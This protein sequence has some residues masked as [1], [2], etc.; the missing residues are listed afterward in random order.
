MYHMPPTKSFKKLLVQIDSAFENLMA[1]LEP[2]EPSPA[3][4][5]TQDSAWILASSE[6][7][8]SG[9]H[10]GMSRSRSVSA[11]R[12]F[13]NDCNQASTHLESNN[14]MA[15]PIQ[16]INRSP[17]SFSDAIYS[18][19]SSD[20]SSADTLYTLDTVECFRNTH[21]RNQTYNRN[22]C[23]NSNKANAY[24]DMAVHNAFNSGN[25]DKNGV[26]EQTTAN[27]DDYNDQDMASTHPNARVFLADSDHLNHHT[28][29]V[30]QTSTSTNSDG[31]LLNANME[32]GRH[33]FSSPPSTVVSQP[34]LNAT[35]PLSD[36]T[37]RVEH[38]PAVFSTLSK[39]TFSKPLTRH[40][41]STNQI[42]DP[43]SDVPQHTPDITHHPQLTYTSNKV[44]SFYQTISSPH[45]FHLDSASIEKSISTSSQISSTLDYPHTKHTTSNFTTAGQ[46]IIPCRVDSRYMS[47]DDADP[48]PSKLPLA[49]VDHV[50]PQPEITASYWPFH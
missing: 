20:I 48:M 30:H 7:D 31:R 6:C 3:A 38:V 15:D 43:P 28:E 39:P 50:L 44:L 11:D 23:R 10:T 13:L 2:L 14:S 36:A 40:H 27:C 18:N 16:I 12:T 5:C 17:S 49:S 21:I 22:D 32:Y 29:N 47:G 41:Q 9:I 34:V 45:A 25:V 19:T 35:K 4:L 46:L 26:V 8:R 37:S 42:L 24:K 33:V 1:D